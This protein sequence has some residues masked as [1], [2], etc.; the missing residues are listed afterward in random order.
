MITR[1]TTYK[2]TW[3]NV[4]N[5]TEEEIALIS[6]EFLLPREVSND[7]VT[8][9]LRPGAKI[10]DSCIYIV[11]HFPNLLKEKDKTRRQEIDFILGDHWVIS[12]SYSDIT[13][14]LDLKKIYD[15]LSN[16]G[17]TLSQWGHFIPK[18]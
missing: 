14:M 12:I 6:G 8:P 2:I 7:I 1:N 17:H 9:T 3:L 16:D 15:D 5:P 10:Y 4:V 13:T 11:Q 18:P